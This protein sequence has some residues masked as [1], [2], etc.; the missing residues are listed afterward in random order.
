[1]LPHRSTLKADKHAPRAAQIPQLAN[2]K[3]AAEVET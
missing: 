2:S 3:A 1:L